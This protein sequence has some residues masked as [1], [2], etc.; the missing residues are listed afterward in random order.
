[1]SRTV[2]LKRRLMPL[3]EELLD[4]SVYADIRDVESLHIFMQH[5]VFAVWDFMS[6]L[7]ALQQKLCC[8]HVPWL[9]PANKLGCRLVNEIVLAEESDEDGH[10]GFVSHFELYR[11]A[12]IDT[13]ADTGG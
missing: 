11:D 7:K 8:L 5:H 13:G 3:R 6:L 4:H 1:M 9:P 12:M 10:G 2:Q